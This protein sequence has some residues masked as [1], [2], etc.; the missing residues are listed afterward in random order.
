MLSFLKGVTLPGFG[1]LGVALAVS[2]AA[3]GQVHANFAALAVEVLAQTLQDLFRGVLGNADH[4]LG[5]IGVILLLD[6]LGSRGLADRAVLRDGTFGDVAADGANIFRHSN[7]L[8][9]LSLLLRRI[10]VSLCLL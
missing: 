7:S 8:L 9:L 4:V 5:H 6:E 10:P 3:H 1:D 2:H